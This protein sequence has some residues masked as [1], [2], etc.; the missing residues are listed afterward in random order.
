MEAVTEVLVAI[1]SVALERDRQ[2]WW[3]G[4]GTGSPNGE[5]E[6]QVALMEKERDRRP[7]WR[8]GQG[9]WWRGG[10]TGALVASMVFFTS[11]NWIY[12]PL[13]QW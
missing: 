6:G 10:G 7:W 1:L 11:E 5:G 3:R 13:C 8:G 12:L 4:R 9:P 2:P